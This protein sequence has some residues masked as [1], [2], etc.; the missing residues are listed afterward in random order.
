M[1][2]NVNGNLYAPHP[3]LTAPFLYVSDIVDE[4]KWPHLMEV[5]KP[6]GFVR[7][8]GKST[9][10][11][12]RARWTIIFTDIFHGSWVSSRFAAPNMLI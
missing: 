7:S 3:L 11:S 8:G 1:S 12:G 6:C 2:T 5:F 9:T 4:L 10:D